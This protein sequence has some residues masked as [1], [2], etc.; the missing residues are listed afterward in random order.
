MYSI[1]Y[2]CSLFG[3][4]RQAYYEYEDDSTRQMI[5]EA[6]VL[7]MVGEIRK[8]LPRSGVPQLLQL[9]KEPFK[10]H[11]IKLGRD[12]LNE[13][14][15]R[16]GYLLRYRRR[17][18][19]TTNSNHA[20]KKHPNLIRGLEVRK[21]NTLWV[22]DITYLRLKRGFAYLSLIT[23]AY[24]RKIVGWHLQQTL[25]AIGPIQALCKALKQRKTITELIHHSDRGIQYCCAEYVKVLKENEIIISMT[26]NGDPYEN[27][28]AERVN[29]IL[30]M[31]LLLD[32]T[33]KT[34]NDAQEAVNWA[35]DK[36]N[37]VRPHSSCDYL[38]PEL[39][40]EREGVLAKHWTHY[41]YK[42]KQNTE[43]STAFPQVL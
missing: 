23:D 33:F 7:K 39:A 22:S 29:G 18:V 43:S 11:G 32:S 35:I 5:K 40:H 1:G 25:H 31:E 37:H 8:N 14:L 16:H 38:T 13:L 6:L 2:Y 36:Y 30:K 24:S 10:E 42:S 4:S 34:F 17:K 21:A 27:A 15:G 28:I 41:P 3:R 12:G 26:E 9:L 20:Y 19:Y